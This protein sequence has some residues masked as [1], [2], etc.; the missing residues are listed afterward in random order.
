MNKLIRQ[1]AVFNLICFLWLKIKAIADRSLSGGILRA[2][3]NFFGR[4]T[5]ASGIRQLFLS[6]CTTD[7]KWR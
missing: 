6:R 3:M 5:D 2:I 1:S 4:L 7:E